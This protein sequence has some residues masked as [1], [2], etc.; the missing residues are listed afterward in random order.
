MKK[1]FFALCM[2]AAMLGIVACEPINTPEEPTVRIEPSSISLFIGQQDTLMTVITPEDTTSLIIWESSNSKIVSIDNKGIIKARSEGEAIITVTTNAGMAQ[3]TVTVQSGILTIDQEAIECNMYESA[4]LTVTKPEHKATAKVTWKS[5]NSDIVSVDSK[6][7]VTA[8][9]AGTAVI[10]ASVSG[11]K[12]V[13]CKVTV[14]EVPLTHARKFLIEHFTGDACGYC[15]YGMYCIVEHIDAATTPYI[16]V[17]HHYGFNQDEYTIDGSSKIGST[18]GVSGA[19]NMA[20]NRTKQE[21]GLAF[22]PGYLPEITIKDATKAAMNV[23]VN[24]TYNA[25]TRQLDITVSGEST[26]ESAG[27]FLLTV[28]IKENRLVGKQADYYY[29]FGQTTWKEY[30]HAR[31]AR[32]FLTLPLGDTITLDNQ[33]Y[34]KT[35]CYTVD[36]NWV[37]ENCCVVAYVTPLSSKPIINAE[38]VVL[39]EGTTG[40]EQYNPYGITEGKGPNNK[41]TFHQVQVSKVEGEKK[42]EVMLVSNDYVSTAYGNAQAIGVVYLNTEAETLAAGTYPIK[43]DGT[44]G[45]ITAGY[46][47]DEKTSFGGSLLIYAVSEYLAMGQ[48]ASAH[49]WRMNEG[50]MVVAEDGSITFNFKTYSGTSVNSTYTKGANTMPKKINKGDLKIVN[51]TINKDKQTLNK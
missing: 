3:C 28:L 24:H 4:L 48:L 34:S 23:K 13:E 12:S 44:M 35:Y 47:I 45:S 33:T 2:V 26:F 15:P 46:R 8:L 7:N 21:P 37:P 16:W 40:G 6:G 36:K 31:V 29:S 14:K 39:V 1:S 19:P 25:S 22:H 27:K 11:C 20:L 51:L 9:S 50:D 32:G 41:I 49:I 5:S 17:S 18:L 43:N 42:L 10:T 38:Q 30:M